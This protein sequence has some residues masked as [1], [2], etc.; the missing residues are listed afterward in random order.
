MTL[1]L[2]PH[3]R[4]SG[5]DKGQAGRGAL[6]AGRVGGGSVGDQEGSSRSR[7]GKEPVELRPGVGAQLCPSLSLS[8]VLDSNPQS[9][10]VE[11]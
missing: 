6:C 11:S 2:F 8:Q 10:N 4:W 9:I 1:G 3:C 7:K 5:E